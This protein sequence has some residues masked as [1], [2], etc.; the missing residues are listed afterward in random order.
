MDVWFMGSTYGHGN[1]NDT[2]NTTKNTTNS[3]EHAHAK[4][5]VPGVSFC[6]ET[7]T[8]R[9]VNMDLE[10]INEQATTLPLPH[11]YGNIGTQSSVPPNTQ[12]D[13]PQSLQEG[14]CQEP[15]TVLNLPQTSDYCQTEAEE[16]QE[17]Q[18][19]PN[20]PKI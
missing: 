3:S 5:R 10:L 2:N 18:E 9:Q 19:R 7:S 12:N 17:S 11:A 14:P 8:W 15:S 4:R 16:G 13:P 1:N 6:H 20:K